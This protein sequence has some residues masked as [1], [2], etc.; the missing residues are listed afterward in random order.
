MRVA[1]HTYAYRDRTLVDGLDEL[2]S[3]GF[4]AVEVWLGHAAEDL[5]AAAKA[6]G[7]RGLET[8]AVSAGGFYAAR[9][10]VVTR[11]VDLAQALKA[12]VI[13]ACVA[14]DVLD[15]VAARVPAGITLCVENHWISLLPPPDT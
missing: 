10:D 14:P 1:G 12:P 13:V 2:A 8:A 15:F 7:E 4:S 11:A 3:L 6:V 5:D 9:T